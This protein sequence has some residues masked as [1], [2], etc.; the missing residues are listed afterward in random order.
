LITG[1]MTI[2]GYIIYFFLQISH[3]IV[4]NLSFKYFCNYYI[5]TKIEN[6]RERKILTVYKMR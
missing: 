6:K 1:L 2:I 5:S 4:K 3:K